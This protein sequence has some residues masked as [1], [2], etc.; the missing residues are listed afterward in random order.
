MSALELQTKFRCIAGHSWSKVQLLAAFLSSSI[1]GN[2]I[3]LR[4]VKVIHEAY[5]AAHGTLVAVV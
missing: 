4:Q 3:S 1:A 2:M 5:C